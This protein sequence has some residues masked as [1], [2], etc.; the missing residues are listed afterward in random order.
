M[1]VAELI[2]VLNKI[3]DKDTQ[4]F[5]RDEDGRWYD[6]EIVIDRVHMYS[7]SDPEG[8]YAIY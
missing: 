3:E 4:I 8:C 1:T 5:Y 6:P 2:E 7:K